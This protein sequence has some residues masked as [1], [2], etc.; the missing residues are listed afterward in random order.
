MKEGDQRTDEQAIR[1]LI[2][3]QFASLSWSPKTS[4]DW[5]SFI[6]D[7]TP[8]ASL[9]PSARPVKRQSV[10]GFVERLAGL[11]AS[12]LRSFR[13]DVLGTEVRVFGNVAVA[14]A[15][16]EVI[17]NESEVNRGVEMLLLVKDQGRWRIVAQAWDTESADTKLPAHLARA[18]EL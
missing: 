4:A 8:G 15:G 1:E 5:D 17:E 12:E 13:E 14:I 2:G 11:A 3:R 18:E 10:D 6:G 9:Y 7:F 16:C